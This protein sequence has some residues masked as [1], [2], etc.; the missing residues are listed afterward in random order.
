M[1]FDYIDGGAE[2]ERTLANNTE[3]LRARELVWR[4]L[5]D[6]SVVDTS[7]SVLGAKSP[8]P[9]ILAPTAAQ[10]LFHPRLGEL[11][12][13]RAA[14]AH[15]A[16]YAV[17]TL[18]TQPVEAIA[19][20]CPGPKVFQVYVWRDRALVEGVLDRVRKAGF[21][22]L[23]LT[24]DAPVAGKRERDPRNGF[25]LPVKINRR[26]LGQ[27]L[28][29]PGYLIDLALGGPAKP[30]NFPHA[31]GGD[32]MDLIDRQFDRSV[33]WDYARW[34]KQAWGGPMAIKGMASPDDARRAIDNG[35]DAVW[36]SNH[37]G[38]Q[39]DTAPASID[40]LPAIAKAVGG[41]AEVIF[42]GGVRRGSDIVKAHALGA[43]A[44]AVGRAYLYGLAA[45]GEAGVDA[46]IRI[47]REDV[48]RTLALLGRPTLSGVDD[49]VLFR[50]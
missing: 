31:G 6:V 4:A 8:T 17:S 13:A 9:F 15:Q 41:Q 12:A 43:D 46:A 45:G 42:D 10:R 18:A 34:L 39:I 44:V 22:A 38:R 1:V 28:A 19:E 37:G 11:A 3:R 25:S 49:S 5:V 29:R 27:A 14:H 35:A 20:A 26:T 50:P 48:E 32:V 47:L 30:S 21:T 36:V 7:I 24:V 2:D 40:T 33:T 23:V 16:I